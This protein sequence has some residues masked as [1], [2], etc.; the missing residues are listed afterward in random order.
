MV[1]LKNVKI[2]R[3]L[4]HA[5]KIILPSG[6]KVHLFNTGRGTIAGTRS[7]EDI[8]K[9]LQELKELLTQLGHDVQNIEYAIQNIVASFDTGKPVDL[10]DLL[11]NASKMGILVVRW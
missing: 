8:K 10:D 6:F 11:Y 5:V 4:G 3:T 2:E 1:D 7:E 9:A